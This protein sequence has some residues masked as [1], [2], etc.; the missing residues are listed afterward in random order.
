MKK[1]L[2][3][4]NTPIDSVY[5]ASKSFRAHYDLLKEHYEFKVISQLGTAT[6]YDKYKFDYGAFFLIRNCLGFT[7]SIRENIF[8][9]TKL[10]L[11][12]I[13]LPLL[14]TKARSV[15]II[16][17]NSLTLIIYAPLLKAFF[18]RKEIICHVREMNNRYMQIT[19][20]CL[21]SVDI[22][23]CI[24]YAVKNSLCINEKK[25]KVI[26]VSNPV[27]I[28]SFNKKFNFD[29]GN[30]VNIGIVGRLSHEKKTIEILDYLKSGQYASKK[31]I[32]VYIVGGPGADFAYY[33]RCK[34]IAKSL[35]NVQY[36]GE[37]NDLENTNFYE[38]LDCLL[39][40]DDHYSVGRTIF[41][42]MNFGV[43][44]Y[45]EKDISRSILGAGKV[46]C[47]SKFFSLEKDKTFYFEKKS[48]RGGF[49]RTDVIERVNKLY[50]SKFL[51]E[52]Y[53]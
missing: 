15:D 17:L 51:A 52:I 28:H 10:I 24:D 38:Q 41:E 46:L 31:P 50:V 42:A 35:S 5:G 49:D 33:N 40:F 39:R 19:S 23:I 48:H 21:N 7:F 13:Y 22:L 8:S 36:L 25:V 37:I 16:H 20:K 6:K 1:V 45:T 34:V 30:Y 12:L 26:V 44:V 14:F 27:I 43:D 3:L 18:P 2:V 47:K 11:G 4:L 53:A 32:M 9:I 29:V